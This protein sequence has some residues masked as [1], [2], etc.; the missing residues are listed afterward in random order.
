MNNLQSSNNYEKH[1][2]IYYGYKYEDNKSIYVINPNK[3]NIG[4]HVEIKAWS[5]SGGKA[6]RST[7]KSDAKEKQRISSPPKKSSSKSTAPK[8]G[9]SAGKPNKLSK[10]NFTNEVKSDPPSDNDDRTVTMSEN[11]DKQE[12]LPDDSKA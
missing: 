1:Y 11:S 8:R 5:R 4:D 7:I 3:K 12:M 10:K 9:R 6:T 2:I